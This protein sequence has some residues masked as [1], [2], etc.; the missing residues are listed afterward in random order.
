MLR[1]IEPMRTDPCLPFSDRIMGLEWDWVVYVC[2][3]DT[4]LPP[5]GDESLL[6]ALNP[7]IDNGTLKRGPSCQVAIEKNEGC[8]H[9][10]GNGNTYPGLIL[11]RGLLLE[12][13][14][15]LE[16]INQYE[17]AGG[18]GNVKH[19]WIGRSFRDLSVCTYMRYTSTYEDA[20][21]ASRSSYRSSRKGINDSDNLNDSENENDS[22]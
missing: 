15:T 16:F 5:T 12:L 7:V 4:V 11:V 13:G 21:S 6:D 14:E 3:N 18:I 10:E 19:A 2:M 20:S 1:D 8:V 9:M 17:S 22:D